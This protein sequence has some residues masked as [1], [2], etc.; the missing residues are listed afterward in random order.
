MAVGCTTRGVRAASRVSLA[1]AEARAV[2]GG[3]EGGVWHP[4]SASSAASTTGMSERVVKDM[5]RLGWPGCM[6]N[7]L[8]CTNNPF[9][10]NCGGHATQQPIGTQNRA[11]TGDYTHGP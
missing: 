4:A 2:P 10:T 1:G 8:R 9:G 7:R 5:V 11:V 3:G 6:N